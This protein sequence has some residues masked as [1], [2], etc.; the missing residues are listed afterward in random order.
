MKCSIDTKYVIYCFTLITF[1]IYYFNFCNSIN[2]G[3]IIIEMS[4]SLFFTFLV[5]NAQST[6]YRVIDEEYRI[7]SVVHNLKSNMEK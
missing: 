3:Y 7:V 4:T 6:V 2:Y 5:Q 1:L